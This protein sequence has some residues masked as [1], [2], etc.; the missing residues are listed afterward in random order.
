MPVK[1]PALCFEAE[2]LRRSGVANG[3]LAGAGWSKG[4]RK[5][6]VNSPAPPFPPAEDSRWKIPVVDA[7]GTEAGEGGR[8]EAAADELGV[9]GGALKASVNEV[10]RGGGA[11]E[12]AAGGAS[13]LGLE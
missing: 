1:S 6:L 9:D 11:S 5:K 7:G 2:E 3:V 13:V 8:G 10:A 12:G 4:L